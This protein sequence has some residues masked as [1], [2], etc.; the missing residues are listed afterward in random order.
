MDTNYTSLCNQFNNIY[1]CED[2]TSRRTLKFSLVESSLVV[3]KHEI[4]EI[5]ICDSGSF[6][7]YVWG[8]DK[9]TIWLLPSG[10]HLCLI[11]RELHIDECEGFYVA[12]KSPNACRELRISTCELEVLKVLAQL[13]SPLFILLD[14]VDIEYELINILKHGENSE[15]CLEKLETIKKFL[16]EKGGENPTEF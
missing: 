16:R 3:F 1:Y 7:V 9:Y 13:N 2:L 14:E 8:S 10:E 5:I 4:R 12:S 6:Q 11:L 15:R